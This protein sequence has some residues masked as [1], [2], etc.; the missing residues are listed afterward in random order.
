MPRWNTFYDVIIQVL[1]RTCLR[2]EMKGILALELLWL[3]SSFA[4]GSSRITTNMY[5]TLIIWP[6]WSIE[7]SFSPTEACLVPSPYYARYIPTSQRTVAT[8]C[9]SANPILVAHIICCLINAMYSLVRQ[10]HMLYISPISKCAPYLRI[11]YDHEG[12]LCGYLLSV[13]YNICDCV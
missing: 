5:A 2:A 3:L 8:K 1:Q 4:A 11:V 7:Y 10:H 13:L 12:R 9:T 6:T